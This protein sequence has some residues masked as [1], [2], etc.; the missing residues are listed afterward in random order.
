MSCYTAILDA[1]V[2]YPSHLRDILIQC[3]HQKF[4]RA[5]WTEKIT[6]EWVESLL[7]KRPDLSRAKIDRTCILM[8]QNVPDSLV[9]GYEF[10]IPSLSLPDPDDRHVLAAAIHCK[11]DSIVTN[12]IKDFPAPVLKNHNIESITPDKFLV[13]QFHLNRKD[14]NLAIKS[15]CV[16]L[17]GQNANFEDYILSLIS[18][19]LIETGEL[20]QNYLIENQ[21]Q[22]LNS[23]QA[24]ESREQDNNVLAFK[25]K[26]IRNR[27]L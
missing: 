13:N 9:S 7:R 3:A 25:Q 10:L 22:T 8:A 5:K 6:E 27:K 12:N 24:N 17:Y 26:Q 19:G 11:A 14:F 2:L 20:V 18:K 1:N 15:I 23:N 16:R 4:F 21:S